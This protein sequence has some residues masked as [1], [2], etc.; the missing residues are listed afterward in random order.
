MVEPINSL[1]N[2]YN[3]AHII[4]H[5]FKGLGHYI[6]SCHAKDT[7]LETNL[8]THINE[9]QPGLGNLDYAVY[10]QGVS[11]LLDVPLMLE[12]MEKPEQYKVMENPFEMSYVSM[13]INDIYKHN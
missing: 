13:P 12:H 9:T 4:K 6:K 5:T 3:N 11:K 8:T 2:Y 1:E 7:I 10:L